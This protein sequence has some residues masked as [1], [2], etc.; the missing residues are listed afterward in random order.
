MRVAVIHTAFLGDVIL[1]TPLLDALHERL[2]ASDVALLTTAL[3]APLFR[4]DPR[5]SLLLPYD[6]RGADKGLAGIW[7]LGMRLRDFRP[8]LLISAHRSLRSALLARLSGA[9]RRIGYRSATGRWLY[10]ETVTDDRSLHE[11]RRILALLGM[12]HDALPT[13]HD[14]RAERTRVRQLLRERGLRWPVALAPGSVWATKQWPPH[15]FRSLA[16]SLVER[17]VPV[18]LLGGP[19]ERELCAGIAA[20][21]PDCHSLAGELGLRESFQLLRRCCA[22]VVNDSAPLHLSQAAGV[23]TF[24]LFGSTVTAFGFG[25]RGP[26]DRVLELPLDCRPCGRHG[27]RRCPLGT[28]ACLET[29]APQLVLEAL[30]S[31]L[32]LRNARL[33]DLDQEE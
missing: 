16:R 12:D 14:D 21:L 20:E 22:A 18:V 3:A 9:P 30:A 5:V 32:T 15:H 8:D 7:R 33:L 2:G 29:L 1:L 24:A 28:L 26:R 13:L 23:P 6:K 31:E 11:C 4:D 19:G 25:P 17:G 27:H 10:T